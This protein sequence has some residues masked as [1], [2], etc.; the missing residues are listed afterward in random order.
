MNPDLKVGAHVQS[1]LLIPLIGMS[2]RR[3]GAELPASFLTS[4]LDKWCLFFLFFWHGHLEAHTG[5]QLEGRMANKQQAN[6][7]FLLLQSVCPE[8]QSLHVFKCI[9]FQNVITKV[10]SAG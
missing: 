4:C 1:L 3:H 8:V 9:L 7:S 2:W 6:A 10:T 5:S